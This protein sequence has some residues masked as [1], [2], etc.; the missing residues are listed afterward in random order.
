MKFAT[1]RYK[2]AE[3]L[4]VVQGSDLRPDHAELLLLH[5]SARS[6]LNSMQGLI[7][8]GADGLNEIIKRVNGLDALSV[9]ADQVSWLAPLPNPRRNIICLGWNYAE[10]AKESAAVKDVNIQE[11]PTHPIIFTKATTSINGPFDDVDYDPRVS[12]RLD[13][14]VELGV[15]IGKSGRHITVAQAYEHIFGYTVINDISARDLQ[16]RHQQFFMG[17]SVDG[18]CPMGPWIITA[19]EIGDPQQLD[20]S[21]KVNG[22]VKQQGNT[23]QQIFDVATTISTLSKV[24][25]LLPGDI[26]ATGT[27]SGVGFARNPPEYLQPGD[28]VECEVENI[29]SIRNKIVA[30]S[31]SSF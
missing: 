28:V 9:S 17:K 31:E 25:T 5:S 16:K 21:C 30:V 7:E 23:R 22:V 8:A 13:W 26:I 29:G 4:A 6:V 1:C 14:E 24:M 27:P 2:G 18:T 12:R 15:I 10:H 20:L 19:D 11:L 3:H